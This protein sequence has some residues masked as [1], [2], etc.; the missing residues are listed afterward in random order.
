[1]PTSQ[2][3]FEHTGIREIIKITSGARA[4]KF[5][6]KYDF[7]ANY[8][9]LGCWGHA[10][11]KNKVGGWIVLGSHEFFNDGPTKQDLNAAS[12]IYHIHFGL[13]HGHGTV[14]PDLGVRD[15]KLEAEMQSLRGAHRQLIH[16]VDDLD[17]IQAVHHAHF[18]QQFPAGGSVRLYQ[19][20][21]YQ[22]TGFLHGD[23]R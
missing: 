6:C 20:R 18:A 22:G 13:D 19:Q 17:A 8:W 3:T 16:V 4:G 14:E 23:L 2:D 15:V 10:S 1:M 21:G 5:D 7:N 9:D 11:D 12:G